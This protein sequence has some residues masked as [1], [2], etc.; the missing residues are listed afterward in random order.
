MKFF[1]S[2]TIAIR[3]RKK[4][5]IELGAMFADDNFEEDSYSHLFP[6]RTVFEW[7]MSGSGISPADLTHPNGVLY[8][9]NGEMITEYMSSQFSSAEHIAAFGLW[10]M[11]SEAMVLGGPPFDFNGANN[12]GWFELDVL[13]HKAECLLCAYQALCYANRVS[14]KINL[15][16][17]EREGI[18]KFDFSA[19]GAA[20]AAK[21][22]SPTKA[23]RE[24][25]LSLYEPSQWKSANQAAHELMERIMVHG[26]SINATLAPSNAQRTIAEWFR[27]KSE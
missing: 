6:I 1:P 19:L 8:D 2:D 11:E 7:L 4:I 9:D 14:E 20:G 13:N 16:P 23:L 12:Q 21:R 18:A 26:R 22:H 25:A 27:K 24:Y 15:T 10:F 3:L 17:E 5:G